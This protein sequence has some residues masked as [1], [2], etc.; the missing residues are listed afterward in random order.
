[1]DFILVPDAL[2]ASE[3]RYA[4][5]K[6]NTVGTRVGSFPVLLETL[7]ELWLLEPTSQNWDDLLQEKALAMENAFWSKSIQI[8]EI[9][10]L[11]QIKKSLQFLFNYKPLGSALQPINAPEDRYSRYVNDLIE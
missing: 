10:T 4:L 11:S 8:D 6:N 2:A 9:A 7:A 5:A 1:M 3:V